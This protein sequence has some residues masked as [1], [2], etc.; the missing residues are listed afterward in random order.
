MVL[1]AAPAAVEFDSASR[2]FRRRVRETGV[3]ASL[4]A[5]WSPQY[6]DKIA[7][8]SMTFRVKTGTCVGLV[9]ANGAGKTTLLKM[10]SGLLHPTSGTVR[11]MGFTPTDRDPEFL[12]RLGMVMGQKSQL[13]ADIPAAETFELLAAVYGVD[14][15]TYRKRLDELTTILKV[16]E[17]L[18]VQVRRL[19]LGERMKCEII[20]SLLHAPEL[21]FLDEPTIGLDVVAKH[22]IREFIREQNKT[23]GTT[24]I[25][26]SHDMSDIVELCDELLFVNQGKLLYAG[27]LANFNAHYNVGAGA[28]ELEALVRELMT[29]TR[30]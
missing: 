6:T 29:G 18:G 2:V 5:F 4:R 16:K 24:I 21:V 27:T 9:G 19:S 26:S 14:S 22:A 17:L 1:S 28:Q 30:T 3:A 20:A 10:A 8:D 7:V 13:W 23:S 11:V 12:S 15:E 25:L